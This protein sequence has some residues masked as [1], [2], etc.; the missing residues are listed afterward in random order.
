MMSF[1][2]KGLHFTED[3]SELFRNTIQYLG[4]VGN[5]SRPKVSL[6]SKQGCQCD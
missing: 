5:E 4:P 6:M 1:K 2:L 3:Q